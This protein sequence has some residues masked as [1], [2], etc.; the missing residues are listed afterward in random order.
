MNLKY[1]FHPHLTDWKNIELLIGE[2]I[3]ENLIFELN[4]DI[5]LSSKSKNFKKTLR[6]HTKS[7]VF[8]SRSLTIDELVIVPTKQEAIDVIQIEEIE[9]LLD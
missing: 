1:K 6:S 2:N 7:V 3:D 8:I 9:R 4:D 5:N